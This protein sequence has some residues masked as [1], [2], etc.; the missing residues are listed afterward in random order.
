M[1]DLM[2]EIEKMNKDELLCLLKFLNIA[3]QIEPSDL[4][5]ARAAGACAR[6]MRMI[7]QVRKTA[8]TIKGRRTLANM[9]KADSAYRKFKRGEKLFESGKRVLDEM[10]A[11][12]KDEHQERD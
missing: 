4:E 10:R 2:S 12:V 9:K 7:R 5:F 1:A 6:G 8:S 3:P 11:G